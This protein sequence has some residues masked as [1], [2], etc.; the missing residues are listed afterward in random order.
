[1]IVASDN[2]L[3]AKIIK[4]RAN[5]TRCNRQIGINEAV[6]EDMTKKSTNYGKMIHQDDLVGTKGA[7]GR[8]MNNLFKQGDVQI[9]IRGSE[10]H[11]IFIE[12]SYNR[13][14]PID[15][16]KSSSDPVNTLDRQDSKPKEQ[17][18]KKENEI[19]LIEELQLQFDIKQF[20]S[21]TLCW[22]NEMV[23]VEG[24]MGEPSRK[25]RNFLCGLMDKTGLIC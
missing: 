7:F 11:S 14:K 20:Q 5:F 16:P 6:P 23:E 18:Y 10:G 8:D 13:Y 1:M 19:L 17:E 25:E 22:C 24:S 21:A 12:I 15:V 4:I 2:R 3:R 9:R